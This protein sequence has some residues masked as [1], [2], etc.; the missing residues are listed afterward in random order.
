MS[1]VSLFCTESDEIPPPEPFI[2]CLL[3]QVVVAMRDL[4]QVVF[5]LKKK[6]IDEAK[7]QLG[8]EREVRENLEY[9]REVHGKDSA[10]SIHLAAAGPDEPCRG[11]G[12]QAPGRAA[13]VGCALRRGG[14]PAATATAATTAAAARG[15]RR[16]R[17]RRWILRPAGSGVGAVQVRAACCCSVKMCRCVFRVFSLSPTTFAVCRLES[18]RWTASRPTRY[19]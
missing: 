13:G 18:S 12:G 3:P 10:R 6:E 5:E 15:R 1:D 8:K 9:M 14:A 2:S 7:M 17:R 11:R 19:Q 4:F 16:G